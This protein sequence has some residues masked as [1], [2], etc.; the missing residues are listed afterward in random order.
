MKKKS[1]MQKKWMKKSYDF[2]RNKYVFTLLLFLLWMLFFDRNDVFTQY[3]FRAKLRKLEND[4][5]YYSEEI[6]KVRSDLNELMGSD[7]NLEK[8]AREKYLMKRDNEDVFIFT[9]S[10]E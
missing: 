8:F 1:I 4:R 9:E 3:R 7:E 6:Q 10:V 2:L 5:N